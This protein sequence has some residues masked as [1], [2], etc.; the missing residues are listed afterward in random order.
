M[1]SESVSG[2]TPSQSQIPP[3]STVAISTVNVV[4][5]PI[6]QVFFIYKLVFLLFSLPFIT[7]FYY[8]IITTYVE[9]DIIIISICHCCCIIHQFCYGSQYWWSKFI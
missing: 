7:N 8:K 1:H 9:M 3:S 5:E 4:G 6:N 2:A